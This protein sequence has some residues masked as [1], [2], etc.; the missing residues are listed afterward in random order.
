MKT[1]HLF[2]LVAAIACLKLTAAAQNWTQVTNYTAGCVAMS[3]DGCKLAACTSTV[4]AMIIST[5][6]GQNWHTNQTPAPGHWPY[7]G[8]SAMASS[9]DGKKLIARATYDAQ[10]YLTTNSG[11]NWTAAPDLTGTYFGWVC[12]SAPGNIF[13]VTAENGLIYVSTNSGLAWTSNAPPNKSW[14]SIASSADGTKLAAA[15][16][17]DK[18]YVSTNF[19]ATWVETQSA[20]DSWR[21]LA[22]PTEQNLSLP[23][24]P[25][26]FQQISAR[27]GYAQAR[28]RGMSHHRPMAPGLLLPGRQFTRL[29]IQAPLGS[30]IT[31]PRGGFRSRLRPMAVNGL[32]PSIPGVSGVGGLH[33]HHVWP[34]EQPPIISRCHGLSRQP[35]FS[36]S[37]IPA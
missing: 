35:T 6:A 1:K 29:V 11:S 14:A 23:A 24:A 3:A 37:K 31:L 8:I 27:T 5:D 10:I 22:T 13:A 34:W 2:A 21:S 30:A 18:I 17:G 33:H 7:V 15:A 28:T 9:A 32:A 36:S 16:S 25:P 12:S 19:G 20:I 26:I 4:H